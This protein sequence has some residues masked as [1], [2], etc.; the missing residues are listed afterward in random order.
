MLL[1]FS[2]IALVVAEEHHEVACNRELA[3]CLEFDPDQLGTSRFFVNCMRRL[4]SPMIW[5]PEGEDNVAIAFL[6]HDKESFVG[7]IYLFF[8]RAQGP[9]CQCHAT[10]FMV[11]VH[12]MFAA[13]AVGDAGS[14]QDD[15]VKEQA[16]ERRN[17]FEISFLFCV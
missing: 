10:A 14:A 12:R 6:S 13:V 11:L 1:F 3:R 4:V 8:F 16:S 7:F 5:S 17:N 15:K 9:W 2:C